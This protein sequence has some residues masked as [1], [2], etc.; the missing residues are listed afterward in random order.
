METPYLEFDKRT[1]KSS[2]K[3]SRE[4]GKEWLLG[5]HLAAFG[6]NGTFWSFRGLYIPVVQYMPD[7]GWNITPAC[8]TVSKAFFT[9]RKAAKTFFCSQSK[10][11]AS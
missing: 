9:S 2:T 5:V 10:Q 3:W 11:T 4:G 7:I 6:K 8:Q 1:N